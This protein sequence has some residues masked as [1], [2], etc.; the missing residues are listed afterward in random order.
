MKYPFET[1]TF[2]RHAQSEHNTVNRHK[3]MYAKDRL[4]GG[5]YDAKLTE[6]GKVQAIKL[7]SQINVDRHD[8]IFTSN[9]SR[10]ID[11]AKLAL[12]NRAPFYTTPLLNERSFG[13]FGGKYI[14]ELE[15]NP[16]LYPYFHDDFLKQHT[17]HW[18]LGPPGGET[19]LQLHMRCEEIFNGGLDHIVTTQQHPLFFTHGLITRSL[20]HYFSITSFE[21]YFKYDIPNCQI[22]ELVR[23]EDSWM[24]NTKLALNK[25]RSGGPWK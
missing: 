9:L 14:S 2:I 22:I 6:L 23:F 3:D 24:L 19:L 20:L 8:I 13:I 11:T 10:A 12:R 15:K 4:Y 1:L 16:L 18:Y 21:D 25:K 7:G 5:L 17:G